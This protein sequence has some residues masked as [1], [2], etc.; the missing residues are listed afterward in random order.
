[1]V[2]SRKVIE[3]PKQD[4]DVPGFFIVEAGDS[5]LILDAQGNEKQ[6]AEVRVLKRPRKTTQRRKSKG[7]ASKL[8]Q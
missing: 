1:V 7:G 2:K 6:P 4:D 8:P 3:L 5:R